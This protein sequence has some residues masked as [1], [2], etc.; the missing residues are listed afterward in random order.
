MT[1]FTPHLRGLRILVLE[2]TRIH[3]LHLVRSVAW[4]R[5]SVFVGT[6]YWCPGRVFPGIWIVPFELAVYEGFWS[7]HV[8]EHDLGIMVGV[9]KIVLG[10]M[11][12]GEFLMYQFPQSPGVIAS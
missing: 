11:R 4:I 12:R 5:V 8:A 6:N 9:P 2:N 7:R 3:C 1:P 10:R